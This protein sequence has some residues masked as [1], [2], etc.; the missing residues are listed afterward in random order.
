MPVNTSQMFVD[1]QQ[2]VANEMANVDAPEGAAQQD[3]IMEDQI[4]PDLLELDSQATIASV[5]P[6]P[7][8]SATPNS[9]RLEPQIQARA[10]AAPEVTKTP[11]R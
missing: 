10:Q 5:A 4:N 3:A 11:T 6:T 1:T 7:S 8:K 2:I 9:G